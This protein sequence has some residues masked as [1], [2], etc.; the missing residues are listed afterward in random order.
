MGET[1]A[2]RAA[3]AA[4]YLVVKPT[5]R[6]SPAVLAAWQ[7]AGAPM[8]G[9][10]APRGS[11]STQ[12]AQAYRFVRAVANAAVADGLMPANPCRAAAR[13]PDPTRRANHGQPHRN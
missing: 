3:L 8:P 12:A 6:L 11:G 5:G 10:K 13:R 1:D 2:G 4:E 7:R 9:S